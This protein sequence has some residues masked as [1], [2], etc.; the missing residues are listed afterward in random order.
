MISRFFYPIGQGAFYAEK[1]KAFNVVYDCGNA[2][3][4]PR[5]RSKNIISQNFSKNEKINIL[6]IYHLDWDHISLIEHLKNTV[7]SIDYVVMPL[8]HDEQ[9]IL[10]SN[11]HRA[12]DYPSSAII[13]T[14]EEFFGE[15]VKIIRVKTS[16]TNEVTEQVIDLGEHSDIEN[17]R[18]VAS[19]TLVKTG[20]DN[21]NWCFIPFNVENVDRSKILEKKLRDSGFDIDKLK[22]DPKYTLEQLIT[23]KKKNELKKIYES[24]DGN[25]NEN[26]LVLYSGPEECSLCSSIG[27][28]AHKY[29]MCIRCDHLG[30]GSKI[31]CIYTGDTDLNK[32]DLTKIY[33]KYWDSVGT[34]QIPH[35]GSEKNF[36]TDFLGSKRL[37]CPISFG[38]KNSYGHPSYKVINDILIKNSY[39]IKVTENMDSGYVQVLDHYCMHCCIKKYI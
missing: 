10:L 26:S 37:I 39:V 14:P 23:K 22:T 6:F 3:L 29:N 35:H 25:I 38:I 5:T 27:H 12:L 19:G 17:G 30:L 7:E 9:K 2:D 21:Y 36:N 31:G 32:F 20:I 11:I 4:K 15:K 24:L 18:V 1:H 16:E 33:G 34:V 8:L 28:V 13:N